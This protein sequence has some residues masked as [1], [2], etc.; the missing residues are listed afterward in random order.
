MVAGRVEAAHGVI[1]GEGERQERPVLL[2]A[3]QRGGSGGVQEVAPDRT[4]PGDTRVVHDAVIV[5]EMEAV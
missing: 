3:F 1:E 5:V 2:D 4:D